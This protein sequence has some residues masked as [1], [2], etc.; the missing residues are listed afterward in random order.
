MWPFKRK[1]NTNA[2]KGALMGALLA[3]QS[4][5][6]LHLREDALPALLTSLTGDAEETGHDRVFVGSRPV[7]V[8]YWGGEGMDEETP[9][10]IT[11]D[12]VAIIPVCG[13][14]VDW[15]PEYWFR[16]YGYASTPMIG[17]MVDMAASDARVSSILMYFDSPGGH[18]SGIAEVAAKIWAVRQA[19][20][21]RIIGV[22]KDICSAAYHLGSQCEELYISKSG[23][24]G[25][26]GTLMTPADWSEM[27]TQFGI[28]RLRITSDGGEKF[29]GAGTLGTK[30]TAE[31]EADWKRLCNEIQALFSADVM[32]GRGFDAATMST[33]ATG[34]Y[35]V[36]QMG[37][38]QKLVDGVASAAAVLSALGSGGEVECEGSTSPPDD[39][40]DLDDPASDDTA[41]ENDR[42]NQE[43]PMDEKTQDSLANKIVAGLSKVFASNKPDPA[44]AELERLQAENKKRE[45]DALKSAR[46]TATAAATA[47]YGQG[48]QELTNALAV[49]ASTENAS[50]LG[51]LESAYKAVVTATIPTGRQTLGTTTTNPPAAPSAPQSE[52]TD[53]TQDDY[54]DIYAMH[55]NKGTK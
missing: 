31:Q 45:E 4:S 5:P 52:K 42:G 44:K 14:L 48:T 36:G 17:R 19:G 46:E 21:K 23:F 43:E 2:A 20:E 40:K 27:Y 50:V 41:T 55:N 11:T 49:I 22:G 18:S 39:D 35:W 51:Q 16:W 1:D 8:A 30:I 32:Q 34:Q 3:F 24:S 15:E 6:V 54:K 33:L 38:T 47:A 53:L 37:V 29:K 28:K 26:I 9:Y 25:C 7:A 12:G 10:D 13:T